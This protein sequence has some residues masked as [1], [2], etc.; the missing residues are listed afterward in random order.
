[1]KYKEL[2]LTNPDILIN[3]E[4]EYEYAFDVLSREFFDEDLE[5]MDFNRQHISHHFV[6]YPPRVV[7]DGHILIPVFTPDAIQRM[8]PYVDLIAKPFIEIV[9]C[10]VIKI[11]LGEGG[12]I[13]QYSNKEDVEINYK[14][15]IKSKEWYSFRAR[16]FKQRGFHCEICNR[17]K[18]LQLHHLTYER[19]GSE[20]DGDVMILCKV[21]HETAHHKNK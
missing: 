20:Q 8:R 2:I 4:N 16:V 17:Q 7:S 19:L 12:E 18:N 21:C 10:D 1:M 6:I 11:Q 9:D 14:E 3:Y 15:Y 5:K 13:Y